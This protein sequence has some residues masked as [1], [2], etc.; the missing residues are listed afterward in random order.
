V[1]LTRVVIST[2]NRMHVEI[3]SFYCKFH[4]RITLYTGYVAMDFRM[5]VIRYL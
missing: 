2:R 3:M 4:I 1:P 5:S